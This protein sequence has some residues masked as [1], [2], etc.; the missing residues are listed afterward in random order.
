M[1]VRTKLVPIR[2]P[3]RRRE[4]EAHEN[5]TH[6][7]FARRNTNTNTTDLKFL[8]LKA[9]KAAAKNRHS[10]QITLTQETTTTQHNTKKNHKLSHHKTIPSKAKQSKAKQ[11]KAKHAKQ[12]TQSRAYLQEPDDCVV[13]PLKVTTTTAGGGGVRHDNELLT[14]V[15]SS[16]LLPGGNE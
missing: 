16:F 15:H 2:V 7:E 6:L 9:Q 11:S 14:L 5:G 1:Q 13:K 10:N 4:V 8:R 3:T 12:S